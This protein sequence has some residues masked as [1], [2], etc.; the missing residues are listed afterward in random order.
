MTLNKTN[1]NMKI[2]VALGGNALMESGSAETTSEN[3]HKVVMNTC[4]YLA[5]LVERGYKMAIVHGNGPQVGRI[6]LASEYAKTVTPAMP[7]DVCGAMSQ[8]YIGYHIQQ[9]LRF[10]LLK[11]GIKTPVATILT[12]VLVSKDDQAFDNPTK[13]IG[14]FYS[15]E[16]AKLVADKTG[17]TI[18]ED[19]GR[20][21]RRVVPSPKPID[22]IEL[23]SVKELLK[24]AI[25]VT[26]G[27]GGIPVIQGEDGELTGISAVI[28]KDHAASL[29]A[30]ELE[31][32]TLL[33][34]TE[35]EKVALNYNMPNQINL[36]K[37]AVAEAE[38]HIEQGHFA[39]GSMLPKIQAAINFVK[40]NPGKRA[41]ITSL[42]KAVDALEGKTGTIIS[43]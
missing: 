39:P 19:S 24:T 42:F 4:N 15:K 32:D 31:A 7:F 14:P 38:K 9:C 13:P 17:Y 26:A 30:F 11:R 22:I 25:V 23:E 20:G 35:V 33:I 3:Q 10:T 41:V 12:Q 37:M 18:I 43:C 2:V 6:V 28:D 1:D 27:G 36:D 34:L 5:E 8:G 40:G 16:E 29:L 21:Y